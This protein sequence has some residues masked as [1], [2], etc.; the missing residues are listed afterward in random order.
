MVGW[1]PGGVWDPFNS[2]TVGISTQQH[3]GGSAALSIPSPDKLY[4][5]RLLARKGDLENVQIRG[6]DAADAPTDLPGRVKIDS[7]GSFGG[8]EQKIL[9]ALP[10][11]TPLSGVYDFVVFSECSIVKGGSISCP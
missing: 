8:V 11:Q 4:R 10:R 5:L 3:V 1:L 9:V 6:Y 2:A 7:R